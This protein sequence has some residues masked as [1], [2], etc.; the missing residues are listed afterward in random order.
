MPA[1]WQMKVVKYQD[2]VEAGRRS[3]KSG[4]SL[5]QQVAH[6]RKKLVK[7]VGSRDLCL[8]LLTSAVFSLCHPPLLPSFSGHQVLC[9][10]KGSDN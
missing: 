7:K 6:Y 4:F 10:D 3:L 1:V 9:V 5:S 2:D 8:F